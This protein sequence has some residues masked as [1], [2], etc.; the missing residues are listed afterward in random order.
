MLDQI[1]PGPGHARAGAGLELDGEVTH[2]RPLTLCQ[3][4]CCHS[5]RRRTAAWRSPATSSPRLPSTVDRGTQPLLGTVSRPRA[6]G[7]EY[8]DTQRHRDHESAR[9]LLLRV[10]PALFTLLPLATTIS[11]SA[12][13]ATMWPDSF[14]TRSCCTSGTAFE[15]SQSQVD[16]V[17]PPGPSGLV[18]G[19]AP[20]RRCSLRRRSRPKPADC[21]CPRCCCRSHCPCTVNSRSG[22]IRRSGWWR[23]CCR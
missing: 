21:H 11:S 7:H 3:R 23:G 19:K 22:A 20:S 2:D 16:E 10:E 8:D 18:K 15:T 9:A 12:R 1:D 17:T 4:A 13:R 5:R 14:T 6:P